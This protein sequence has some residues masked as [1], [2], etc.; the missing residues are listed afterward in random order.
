MFFLQHNT[1]ILDLEYLCLCIG[2]ES[3]DYIKNCDT[4]LFKHVMYVLE[5]LLKPD[6]QW[7]LKLNGHKIH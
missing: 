3:N 6:S 7:L 2:M 1:S 5:A 4:K